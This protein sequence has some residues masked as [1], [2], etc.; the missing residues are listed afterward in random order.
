MPNKKPCQC[1]AVVDLRTTKKND[2]P[3]KLLQH[4]KGPV[5]GEEIL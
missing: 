4:G 5:S 3:S 1:L 2:E